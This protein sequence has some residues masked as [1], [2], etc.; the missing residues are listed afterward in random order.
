[1]QS[2]IKT[3]QVTQEETTVLFDNGQGIFVIYR[4]TFVKGQRLGKARQRSAIL[5]PPRMD[6]HCQIRS[7]IGCQQ[8]LFMVDQEL[9]R[10]FAN[11]QRFVTETQVGQRFDF[12]D[13]RLRPGD[14]LGVGQVELTGFVIGGN[15]LA[16]F[17]LAQPQQVALGAQR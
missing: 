17:A 10:P 4:R 1:M 7:N 15:G 16:E 8:P 11:S 13:L 5:I 14:G 3:A 2:F 6:A 9:L 12:T